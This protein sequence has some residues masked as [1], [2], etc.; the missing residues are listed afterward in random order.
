MRQQVVVDGALFVGPPKTRSGEHRRV[1]LDRGT[2]Q[3]LTQHR[4]RQLE[5]LADVGL[6]APEDD[7]VFTD[8]LGRG[9]SPEHVTRQFKVIAAPAGLPVKRL[10]DLR[11]GS[12][13]LQLAAGVDIAVVSK[14]LGHSTITLT[15]D[16]YS[17]LLRGVGA[18]AA[19]RRRRRR[20]EPAGGSGGSGI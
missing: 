12:A 11:R 18:D 5:H 6:T 4:A 3:L 17:H 2:V 15:A 8:P 19:A 16:T 14:R 13:S 10:H 1:D 7:R 9:I 20:R